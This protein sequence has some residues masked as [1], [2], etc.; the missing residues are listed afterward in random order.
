[1]KLTRQVAGYIAAAICLGAVTLIVFFH[2]HIISTV[3]ASCTQVKIR[4]NKNVKT[5][6]A[7]VLHI[8]IELSS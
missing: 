1:M 5:W 2:W 7:V 4:K 8:G 6:M 3:D